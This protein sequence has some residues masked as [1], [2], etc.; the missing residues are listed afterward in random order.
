MTTFFRDIADL[1]SHYDQISI[2]SAFA[3]V[4]TELR[5]ASQ[6]YIEPFVGLPLLQ[7]LHNEYQ[8]ST[9]PTGIKAEVITSLKD[10]LVYYWVYQVLPQK[11][12]SFGAAGAKATTGEHTQN[13]SIS[14]IKFRQYSAIDAA[15]IFLNRALRFITGNPSVFPTFSPTIKAGSKLFKS[16]EQVEDLLNLKGFRAFALV[17]RWLRRIEEEDLTNILGDAFLNE[18]AAHNTEGD[19]KATAKRWAQKFAAAKGLSA[20]LPHLPFFVDGDGLRVL[21]TTSAAD[22]RAHVT[23][24]HRQLIEDLKRSTAADAERYKGEL[25]SYLFKNAT[26]FATWQQSEFYTRATAANSLPKRTIHSTDAGAIFI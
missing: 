17:S 10:A 3:K 15:D 5:Q 18:L 8:A 22:K 12:Y 14:E 13:L 16:T 4:Q 24:E 26:D 23:E 25:V 9:P 7:N 11:T 19:K 6:G 21:T 2:N 20:A 1:K